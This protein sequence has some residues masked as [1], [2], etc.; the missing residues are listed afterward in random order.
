MR[1][2]THSNWLKV[3]GL[4]FAVLLAPMIMGQDLDCTGDTS[5]AVLEF[6][7]FQMPG[8]DLPE[9]MLAFQH[10]VQVYRVELPDQVTQ[11]MLV[12]E[13]TDPTADIMVDCY[14]GTEWVE[15]HTFDVELGWFVINLPEPDSIVRVTVTAAGGAT[16][17]YNIEVIRCG[18]AAD[19]GLI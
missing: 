7:P 2:S 18:S 12:A 16:D 9:D 13:P 14:V 6:K 17:W 19:C 8:Q 15:G 11:A 3:L 10:D 1:Y 4:A 5:L